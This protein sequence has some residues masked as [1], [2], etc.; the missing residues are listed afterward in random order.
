MTISVLSAYIICIG[1]VP[2]YNLPIEI[3]PSYLQFTTFALSI[4][5]LVISL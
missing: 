1:A 5:L 2:F 4:F 3:N